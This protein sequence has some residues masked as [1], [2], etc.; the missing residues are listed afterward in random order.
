MLK[1]LVRKKVAFS[2]AQLPLLRYYFC[3]LTTQDSVLHFRGMLLDGSK[4][5]CDAKANL[6]QEHPW[7]AVQL[8]TP[9]R[10][11]FL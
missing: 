8:Q 5:G 1:G 11:Y 4:P 6:D 3:G 9:A 10:A 7:D 2:F